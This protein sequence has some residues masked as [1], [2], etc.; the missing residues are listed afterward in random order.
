MKLKKLWIGLLLCCM[1]AVII[2][3]FT[4]YSRE[5]KELY[6]RKIIYVRSVQEKEK[7][8]IR[9]NQGDEGEIYLNYTDNGAG[10]VNPYFACLAAQGLLAGEVAE[11][12]LEQVKRYL[13]WHRAH[14][15]AEEGAI[16]NYR[17]T[18]GELLS[19]GEKDS[20]DSYTAVFLSLLCKYGEKGGAIEQADPGGEAM[21]LGL[22]TLEKLWVDGLTTVSEEKQV[23]Y[24]M[25]NIEVQAALID[26][27][28]Y[29][30][31]LDGKW[32][33]ADTLQECAD[34]LDKMIEMSRDSIESLLWNEEEARYDV[35]LGDSGRI[36]DF[37]SWEELYP[38]AAVQI[39]G[40]AFLSDAAKSGRTKTLY[41][42]FC[43]VHDWEHMS[44][45]NEEEFDWAVF[46]FIA[47]AVGDRER[48][49]TYLKTYERRI[50]EG[51]KYPFHTAEAGWVSKT[52]EKLEQEYKEV[53]D[54][55]IFEVIYYW[56][57]E[58]AA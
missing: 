54:R 52:C 45:S 28:E 36:L 9:Q 8:W 57:K 27:R 17:L 25:D 35:G 16:S 20:V 32:I 41:K 37:E 13:I 7:E 55:N 51:R 39:Y 15:L 14:F 23:R 6:Q 5:Q 43:S 2:V 56:I 3:I 1:L 19:Q 50:D 12:D 29:L 10:D 47:A 58:R 44:L 22:R 42:K 53:I 11:K 31:D 33:D 21:L 38:D 46:S 49:E 26:V 18:E 40:A 24:L 34:R 4:N 48:A 30:K